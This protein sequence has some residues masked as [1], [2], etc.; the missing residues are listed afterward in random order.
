[1][2][3]S[4]FGTLLDNV[5]LFP[6]NLAPVSKEHPLWSLCMP[7]LCKDH[8]PPHLASPTT[9]CLTF[10]APC[11]PLLSKVSTLKRSVCPKFSEQP[12]QIVVGFTKSSAYLGG[13]D[14]SNFPYTITIIFIPSYCFC[15]S[16]HPRKPQDHASKMSSKTALFE[17]VANQSCLQINII[18]SN[19]L[20]K[21]IGYYILL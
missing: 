2:A 7:G 8:H 14:L 21:M 20:Q 12:K 4:K 3:P 5:H 16:I 11:F 13:N 9:P 1:M 19:N 10:P 15:M 18:L 17:S 6:F